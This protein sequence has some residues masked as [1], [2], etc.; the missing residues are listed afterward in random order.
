METD[1]D[2]MQDALSLRIEPLKTYLR[3]VDG[4]QYTKVVGTV[5]LCSFCL[6]LSTPLLCT[7]SCWILFLLLKVCVHQP[8]SI[9]EQQHIVQPVTGSLVGYVSNNNNTGCDESVP[10]LTAMDKYPSLFVM[11]IMHCCFQ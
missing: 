11:I 10:P 4:P 3:D 6:A 5:G 1:A 8:A 7:G 9:R 2:K